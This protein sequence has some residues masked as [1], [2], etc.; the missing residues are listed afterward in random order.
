MKQPFFMRCLVK[1]AGFVPELEIREEAQTAYGMGC[2]TAV[3]LWKQVKAAS[4]KQYQAQHSQRGND[5]SRAPDKNPEV[6]NGLSPTR[7]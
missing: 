7:G 5:S 3:I 1:I 6:K 2:E 4:Y